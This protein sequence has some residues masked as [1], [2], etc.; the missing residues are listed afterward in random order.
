MADLPPT[1]NTSLNRQKERL[2]IFANLFPFPALIPFGLVLIF[3]G[4]LIPTLNPRIGSPA[5][6]IPMSSMDEKEG[7]IWFAVRAIGDEVVVTAPNKRIFRWPSKIEDPRELDPFRSYLRQR[8][9]NEI[10]MAV[11]AKRVTKAQLSAVI[12]A[13]Q[14][15]RYLHLR[16]IIQALAEVG[17]SDY[18]FET[19]I[20]KL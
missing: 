15:C 11:L 12:A 4:S 2:G 5:D 18:G 6:V 13:D 17:I 16:P 19:I 3:C 9:T 10:Q 14:R 8:V 20:N 1:L 7:S